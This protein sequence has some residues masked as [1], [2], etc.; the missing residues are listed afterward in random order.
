MQKTFS[1]GGTVSLLYNSQV[2]YPA[3]APSVSLRSVHET[4]TSGVEMFYSSIVLQM[5]RR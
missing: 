1:S 3:A 4:V 5:I 2:V